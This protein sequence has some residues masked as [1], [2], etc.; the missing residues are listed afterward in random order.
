VITFGGT[1]ACGR[2]CIYDCRA[3]VCVISLALHVGVAEKRVLC[4]FVLRIQ[5]FMSV[6]TRKLCNA[7][8][9]YAE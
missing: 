8:I 4:A 5:I 6:G 7:R 3:I 1:F 9:L 2:A